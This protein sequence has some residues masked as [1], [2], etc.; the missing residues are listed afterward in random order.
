MHITYSKSATPFGA[1]LA[2]HSFIPQISYGCLLCAMCSFSHFGS[3]QDRQSLSTC[4]AYVLFG[5]KNK[6]LNEKQFQQAM[7]KITQ[8]NEP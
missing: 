4:G 2:I 7:T 8:Y 1:Y 3:E 5:V 6:E